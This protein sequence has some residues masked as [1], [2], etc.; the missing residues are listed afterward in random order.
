V[1]VEILERMFAAYQAGGVEAALEFIAPDF[2]AVVGPEMSAEPDVYRGH[3][4]VRRYFAGFEGIEDVRLTPEEFIEDGQRVMVPT[5]LSGRGASS[6]IEVEQRVV[7]A[8][9]FR[10]GKALRLEVFTDLESAR[11]AAQ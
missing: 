7:Q 1:S 3:D 2:E 11:E 6:G 8:W 10:N 4:G 5:V 9:Q